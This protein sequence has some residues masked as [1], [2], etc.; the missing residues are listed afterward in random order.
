MGLGPLVYSS[1]MQIANKGW[2]EMWKIYEGSWGSEE[3]EREGGKC[4]CKEGDRKLAGWLGEREYDP[5]G[6]RLT[7]SNHLSNVVFTIDIW[8][9]NILIK[10]SWNN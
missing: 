10:D 4:K 2:K 5:C 8:E 3:R 1:R 6:K 7:E 9:K